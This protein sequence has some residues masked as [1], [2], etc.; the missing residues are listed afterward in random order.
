[1]YSK[2]LEGTDQEN[3]EKVRD[4]DPLYHLFIKA[5]C[6]KKSNG[7]REVWGAGAG[8]RLL[9]KHEDPSSNLQHSVLKTKQNKQPPGLS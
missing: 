8:D 3:P 4:V 1:M 7:K 6:G 9:R 2:S 5:R